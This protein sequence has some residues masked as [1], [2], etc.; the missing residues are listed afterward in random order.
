[1]YP[2]DF[3]VTCGA[4]AYLAIGRLIGASAHV[5]GLD[6]SNASETLKNSFDAPEASAAENCALLFGHD[7]WMHWLGKSSQFS[8][9]SFLRF[10]LAFAFRE[11]SKNFFHYT[12][13]V[14]EVS[15]RVT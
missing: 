2:D 13:T 4:A 7:H 12:D 11:N 8:V 1:M 14:K 10:A 15:V 5:T 3:D 9:P 6:M